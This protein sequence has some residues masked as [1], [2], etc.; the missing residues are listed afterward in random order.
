MKKRKP[1]TRSRAGPKKPVAPP[2]SP[3]MRPSALTPEQLHDLLRRGGATVVTAE[4]IAA[5]ITAG[6]PT[7]DDSTVNLVH[8]T[9]WLVKQSAA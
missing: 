7:N 3:S 5:D 9:A 8:Y 4:Q 2:P 1:S 6:A